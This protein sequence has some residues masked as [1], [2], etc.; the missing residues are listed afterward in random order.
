MSNKEPWLAV[1]LSSLWM[2]TGQIYSGYGKKGVLLML[3]GLILSPLYAVGML[4]AMAVLLGTTPLNG[5][6][7]V[8]FLVLP[9]SIFLYIWNLIDAYKL[10]KEKNTSDF[11]NNR[12]KNKDA[13]FAVLL[14]IFQPGLGHIYIGKTIIGFTFIYVS[15]F[16]NVFY[17]SA[18]SLLFGILIPFNKTLIHSFIIYDAYKSTPVKTKYFKKKNIIQEIFT[19]IKSCFKPK[20][21]IANVCILLVLVKIG[22]SLNIIHNYFYVSA[23]LKQRQYNDFME[24]TLLSSESNS[25]ADTII[26]APRFIYLNRTS[27][28]WPYIFQRGFN[29]YLDLVTWLDLDMLNNLESSNIF[30]YSFLYNARREDIIT[31]DSFELYFE[32]KSSKLT[33]HTNYKDYKEIFDSAQRIIGMP[34]DKVELKEGKV[35]INDKQLKENYLAPG[36][37]TELDLCKVDFPQPAYLSKPVTIP[38]K[39]YLVLGDNRNKSVDGR[40]WG[41]IK[42]EYIT[43]K[44]SGIIW[45]PERQRRL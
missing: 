37:T 13:W 23:G 12:K 35:Y 5:F 28:R 24:P 36:Q 11:E 44:V 33:R 32:L 43:G 21:V 29:D 40:C 20:T 9:V 30:N 2:G 8:L 38:P 34:G 15:S 42:E 45:P 18:Y 1:T 17:G 4:Y 25:K 26:V 3:L 39:S 10:A 41:V 27:I 16:I 14:S 22:N 31:F 7:V 19:S 6:I